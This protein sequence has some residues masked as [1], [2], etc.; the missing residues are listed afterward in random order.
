M[1][2]APG[3]FRTMPTHRDKAAMKGLP[4]L[5]LGSGWRFGQVFLC[6]IG[7][8]A[9]DE[10]NSLTDGT[11]FSRRE[12]LAGIGKAAVG[13][14]GTSAFG[15]MA[16]ASMLRAAPSKDIAGAGSLR[17]RGAA[18]GLLTGFAVV[19]GLLRSDAAYTAIVKEQASLIVAENAMK[20]GALRPTPDTYF[21]DDADY[22]LDFA[23][24]SRMKLRGHNLL[25]HR[26][27]PKWFEATATKENARKLLE[28]H[29]E[30]VAGRYAGRLHSWDVVNEAI[31]VSDGRPDGLRDS[32][33]LRLVGDDYIEVAFRA[34]R[35]ADPQALLAYNDYG[36]E[37]E[38]PGDEAKRQAVL[39]ML[40]R[41]K[42]RQVPIDA[43]GIQSHISA[44]PSGKYGA[45]LMKFIAS[46]R[47]LGLQVFVT[48]MDVNDR[49]VGPDVA[50]RDA[51][52]ASAYA[53]YLDLVLNDPAVTAVVFWGVTDKYTWLNHED[54]RKD[55]VT[56]RPL[57]FDAGGADAGYK[58]KQ[59]FFAARDAF[60][61]RR[62]IHGSVTKSGL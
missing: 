37:A 21:F 4:D 7:L 2:G 14:A 52:V 34:A 31:Q 41:L 53:G 58:A 35:R 12:V 19:P 32:P 1:D 60:D 51:A 36:I 24:K 28:S 9:G 13:L 43:V 18:K 29:I 23:E 61:K 8:R 44:G 57:L 54:A 46:V 39:L 5:W 26:S 30:T 47:E 27:L 11:G 50:E 38:W 56:E 33:W 42:A 40:R 17:A 48:E 20:W 62:A 45:G 6:S 10:D 55:G 49:A 3:A 22:L 15:G 25:W 59:S 16:A